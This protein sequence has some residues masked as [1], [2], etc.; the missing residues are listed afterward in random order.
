MP[1]IREPLLVHYALGDTALNLDQSLI[2]ALALVRYLPRC[3]VQRFQRLPEWFARDER[4]QLCIDG[5]RIRR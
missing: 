5:P 1:M 2:T 3:R 4:H